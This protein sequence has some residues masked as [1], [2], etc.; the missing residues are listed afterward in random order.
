MTRLSTI[1]YLRGA[2]LLIVLAYFLS[3][4]SLQLM[5]PVWVPFLLA[6]AV[7]AEFFLRKRK[8]MATDSNP[9]PQAS[10]IA[11]LGYKN[12]PSHFQLGAD[13]TL[14]L[15]ASEEMSL[16]EKSEWIGDNFQEL[17]AL[18]PGTHEIG[19]VF[20]GAGVSFWEAPPAWAPTQSSTLRRRP[21]SKRAME[22]LLI[23]CV[24]AGILFLAIRPTGWQ[25]LNAKE[26]SSF[27]KTLSHYASNIAGHKVRV[28]CDETG[29]KV[30]YVEDADGLAEVGGTHAWLT[31]QICYQL[32]HIKKTHHASGSQDAHAIAVLAHESW[33]LHG[34]ANEGLA[35][36]FG[37]QSGVSVG[38]EL[39][40]TDKKSYELMK[41]E[42][43]SNG[44]YA[45]SAPAYLVPSGCKDGA[46][47]DLH[48]SSSRFP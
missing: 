38:R 10:D 46:Q 7:E 40:L 47:Y 8:T 36:C 43:G 28:I 45:D 35:N 37:Y 32:Y 9:G 31:P 20:P 12:T 26:K 30:G 25:T 44:V 15:H 23:L 22:A 19:P 11:E 48:P 14:T 41:S 5:I 24:V 42:L 21:L 27:S 39:G 16:E 1:S 2:V 3:P 4:D 18:G 13:I 17:L 33:H 34:E 6:L 29:K